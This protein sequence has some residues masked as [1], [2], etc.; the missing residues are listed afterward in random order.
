MLGM[1][2]NGR[3][4]AAG[5]KYLLVV[6]GE[7]LYKMAQLIIEIVEHELDRKSVV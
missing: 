6:G 5:F 2:V 1:F 4:V 7:H 3:S